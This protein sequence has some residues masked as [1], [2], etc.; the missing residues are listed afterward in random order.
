MSDSH[1]PPAENLEAVDI[2]R[3][4]AWPGSLRTQLLVLS[5]VLLLAVCVYASF[6]DDFMG[7]VEASISCATCIGLLAPLQALA[8]LGDD[9]FVDLFVGFCTKL[10]AR[11][12]RFF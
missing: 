8:R 1:T 11:V 6:V 7:D 10:G 9:A 3:K 5:V 2:G 12:A 4:S